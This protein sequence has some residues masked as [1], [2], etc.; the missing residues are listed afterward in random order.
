M[1][2]DSLEDFVTRGRDHLGRGPVALVFA[3]DAAAVPETLEHHRARGFATV[4]LLAPR[5]V[6]ARTGDAGDGPVVL[7]DVRQ[8]PGGIAAGVSRV[9]AAAP[10]G[11]WVYAG[12]N[13]EFLMHPFCETRT[14]AEMLAF[15]AEERRGAVPCV[16]VDL[17][18]DDLGA[19][20]DGVAAGA[21]RG[22]AHLDAEGYYALPVRDPANGWAERER[23]VEI[24]G[25]LRWRFEAH[26]PW[27]RRRL[28][29]IALVRADRGLALTDDWRVAGD[30]ERNTLNCPWHR[31][32][33]A[34]VASCR[35][36]KALAGNPASREQIGSFLG[37][38]S[39]RFDWTS[40]QL[41]DLGFMEPG[42]WF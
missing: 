2:W 31:N 23:Q 1:T 38:G 29:R 33:T 16:T 39:V 34:A 4:V 20:P 41:M 42:Q 11:V 19:V 21:S 10:P 40:R 14:V 13:A 17:Y 9:L 28:D 25:G 27:N 15:H 12:Y 18:P 32:L 26:V 7:H 36:A 35:V 6:L 5:W 22:R 3:E 30:A 8:A 37:P 24:H